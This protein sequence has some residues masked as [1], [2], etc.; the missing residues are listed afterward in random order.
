MHLFSQDALAFKRTATL[1]DTEIMALLQDGQ[2]DVMLAAFCVV[3]AD[4]LRSMN[5][6]QVLSNAA[7]TEFI[8]GGLQKLTTTNLSLFSP[9]VTAAA[10]SCSRFVEPSKISSDMIDFACTKMAHSS[11][12]VR[13][14]AESF[15]LQLRERKVNFGMVCCRLYHPVSSIYGSFYRLSDSQRYHHLSRFVK[16]GMPLFK[17]KVIEL[18]SATLNEQRQRPYC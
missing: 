15:L 14:D 1:E 12:I 2:D 3:C 16:R 17:V 10:L 11:V 8:D 4:I 18:C 13:N 6:D 5:V 9:V 7:L